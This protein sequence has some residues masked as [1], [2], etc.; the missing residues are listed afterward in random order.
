MQL[1]RILCTFCCAGVISAAAQNEAPKTKPLTLE[2]AVQMALEH[3]YDVKVERFNPQI[4]RFNL[5]GSYSVYEPQLGLTAV[6]SESSQPGAL[7]PL[8]GLPEPTRKSESDNF[9]GNLTPGISGLFPTGTKYFLD[10][11]I[12][13]STLDFGGPAKNETF[14]GNWNLRLRQPLLRDFWIDAGR[15]QI[16]I[17]KRTLK[18][19]ELGLLLQLMVTIS[20]V[21]QAYYNLIF[22]EESVKVQEKARELFERLLMETRKKVEVGSLAQLEEKQA[23]SQA[24]TSKADL[25]AA[26]RNLAVQEN[27]LKSLITSDFAAWESTTFIP[28]EKLVAVPVPL[29]LQES[30]RKGLTQ[31]PDLQQS[32]ED[33]ERRAITLR[34]QKNQLFPALDLIGSYGHNG[35][36]TSYGGV[37]RDLRK[38]EN[39]SHSYGAILSIPLGN[40]GPRNRYKASKAEKQQAL[41]QLKKLEQS[42]MV[43]IDDAVKL[44][45]TDLERVEATKQARAFA[46]AALDA[47]QKK[48]ENGKST[49]FLVLQSTRDVTAARFEEIRA[50]SEYNNALAQLAFREGATLEKHRINVTIK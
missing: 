14:S 2:E 37:F 11:S 15:A 32:R 42:I 4:A 9:S 31:R 13:H 19:S 6:H 23:E 44:V 43:Q 41:L 35:L 48:L 49:P 46:E 16:S 24:A 17:N 12:N 21:E 20:S 38:D 45:Q 47:E 18:I 39:P 7:N 8:T 40:T 33:L 36:D 27:V 5:S 29:N 30:W 34:Y 22:A 25:L 28:A 50:L 1:I 10:S 26:Q 3:N